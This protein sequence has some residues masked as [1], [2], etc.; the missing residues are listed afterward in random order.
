MLERRRVRKN[1]TAVPGDD[2]AD[3]E[4]GEGHENGVSGGPS[5]P[6]L[7]Q[8]VDDWDENAE[9]HWDEEASANVTGTTTAAVADVESK[10]D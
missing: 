2:D 9:D 7:E 10:K 8:E 3:L 6:T 5:H 1:Y 4:L